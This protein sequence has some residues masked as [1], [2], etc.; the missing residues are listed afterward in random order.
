MNEKAQK[1][2]KQNDRK[3]LHRTNSSEILQELYDDEDFIDEKSKSRKSLKSAKSIKSLKSLKSL[4][5]LN[6]SINPSPIMIPGNNDNPNT[7]KALGTIKS[8][9]SVM[10]IPKSNTSFNS[11]TKELMNLARGESIKDSK[12]SL[13]LTRPFD[14]ST[15]NKSKSLRKIPT[16][17]LSAIPNTNRGS[18]PS[19]SLQRELKYLYDG[20][21][22]KLTPDQEHRFKKSQMEELAQLTEADREDEEDLKKMNESFL[23]SRDHFVE[24]NDK[25]P[26]PLKHLFACIK[27]LVEY[28]EVQ[29]RKTRAVLLNIC[30]LYNVFWSP[31]NLAFKNVVHSG[32]IL[33]MEIITI[34]ILFM[35]FLVDLKDYR[36][37]K[38]K[39]LQILAEKSIPSAVF[40]EEEDK[41]KASK[42]NSVTLKT[43]I[44]DFL[45]LIPFSLILELAD[46]KARFSNIF[47]ILLQF[48]RLFSIDRITWIFNLEVFKRRYAL[49]NILMIIYAYIIINHFCACIL[50]M[51]G[52]TVEDFNKTWLAKLPAPQFDYP[53]NLRTSLDLTN[54][55]IYLGA[56]YWAYV[57]T[58]HVGKV[59]H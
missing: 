4:G 6:L 35:H 23:L 49:G 39:M 20:L 51:I 47:L 38:K 55:T 41:R 59:I 8:V 2:K 26:R 12:G 32:G 15:I 31:Y 46:V 42:A 44:W 17:E 36:K 1:R 27:H 40:L 22:G 34:I 11:F 13:S 7:K 3:N 37:E 16:L 29:F 10:K 56:S 54:W 33:V 48:L 50:I 45:Y 18:E 58:S 19:R 5:N 21:D 57:T 43:V 30:L 52:N 53:R 24:S 25:I 9:K 28:I 14:F